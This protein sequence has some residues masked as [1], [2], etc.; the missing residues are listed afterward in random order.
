MLSV[1]TGENSSKCWIFY[2]YF[3]YFFLKYIITIEVILANYTNYS[4][5]ANYDINQ[6]SCLS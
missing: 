3:N 6:V 5:N 1:D 2:S 4:C